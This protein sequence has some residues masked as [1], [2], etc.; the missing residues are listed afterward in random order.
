[1]TVDALTIQSY[2]S[3]KLG[4]SVTVDSVR[5]SFP[6]I[7]RETW[8]VKATVSGVPTGYVLRIDPPEGSGGPTSLQFEWQVYSALWG[9]EIPVAKPLWYAD[10]LPFA[11]GR[12]HMVRALVDGSTT[13]EGLFRDTAEA[14]QLRRNVAIE[15][16]RKLALV[17]TFNWRAAALD[18]FIP[19]PASTGEC[20]THELQI[21]REHWHRF[22]PIPCPVIEEAFYWLAPLAPH[23]V[24][25]ISLNKGNNGI[26]EEIWRNTAIVAMSDWELASI[27]D[28]VADLFW[29]QGTLRLIDF[30]E[31]VRLYSE[32]TGHAVSPERLAFGNAFTLLKQTICALAFW[33]RPYHEGRTQ[34]VYAL[35]GRTFIHEIEHRLSRC[36]GRPL[37]ETWAITRGNEKNLYGEL[38]G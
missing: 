38:G 18:S 33:Y 13:V 20:W 12:P 24:P 29:S 3:K 17:H 11:Q 21:W 2:F 5:Q 6:G 8:L 16:V 26:G 1:M 35:S 10:G 25:L 36:L 15:A 32:A 37:D 28:G 27:G 34:R 19:A 4:Q 22:G 7:S 23:D 14:A 30:D 31:I 9:T